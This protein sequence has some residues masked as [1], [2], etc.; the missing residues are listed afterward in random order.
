MALGMQRDVLLRYLKPC[1]PKE[2]FYAVDAIDNMLLSKLA[3]QVYALI[4]TF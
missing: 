4:K 1:D 2:K 3:N